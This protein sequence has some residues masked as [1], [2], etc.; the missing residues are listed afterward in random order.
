MTDPE[1][2]L[3][4]VGPLS[5]P[6]TVHLDSNNNRMAS[7]GEMQKV[8]IISLSQVYIVQFTSTNQEWHIL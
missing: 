8:A 5:R 6:L 3:V 1:D 7:H 4:L 2:E